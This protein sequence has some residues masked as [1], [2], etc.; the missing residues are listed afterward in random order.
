MGSAFYYNPGKMLSYNRFLNCVIGARGIGKSYSM[1]EHVIK[2]FLKPDPNKK[3]EILEQQFIYLR[4][5]KPE[6]K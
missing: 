6:L 5:Y 4:R 3:G 1:K 2:Q